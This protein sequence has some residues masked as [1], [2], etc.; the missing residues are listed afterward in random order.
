MEI[1]IIGM[2]TNDMPV[3]T[4]FHYLKN[5]DNISDDV[6]F[7]EQ[8]LNEYD[9]IQNILSIEVAIYLTRRTSGCCGSIIDNLRSQRRDL[10]NKYEKNWGKKF[11][12]HN[13]DV[14]F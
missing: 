5:R 13:E 11:I 7:T 9:D 8:E 6:E 12:D 3:T 4:S 10:I 2:L 14:D 1:Q